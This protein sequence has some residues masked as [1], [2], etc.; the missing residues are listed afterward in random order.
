MGQLRDAFEY[1]KRELAEYME[2]LQQT[3]VRKERIESELRIASEI[4]MGMIPKL[5]PPFP[6]RKDIDLYAI[7]KPAKEVGGDLYDFFIHEEK[8]LFVIG[9]VSGKGIPASLLMAVTRSLFRTIAVHRKP[10]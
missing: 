10:T 6:E 8:L 3:T 7:L 2:E 4:Q 9:D 5:F 1:M